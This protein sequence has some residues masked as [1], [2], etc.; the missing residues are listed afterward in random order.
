MGH[1]GVVRWTAVDWSGRRT[2]EGRHLWVAT[3]DAAGTM[4]LTS[5]RS[6]VQ[7][8]ADLIA[9][10]EHNAELVVGLDLSFGLPSWYLD[11]LGVA[12]APGLWEVAA[13]RGEQWLADCPWPFW[14]RPQRPRP[15][16][17]EQYR[18]TEHRLRRAGLPAKAT[19]QIGGAG[20]VG[21]GSVRGWPTLLALRRAGFA[22]WPFDPPRLP[23]VVEVNP[24]A[25]T[26]AVVKSDWAAR[27]AWLSDRLPG[28][29]TAVREPAVA[30]EDAFDALAT[31]T[32]LAA[33]RLRAPD[34]VPHPAAVREGWV[35]VPPAATP[36]PSSPTAGPFWS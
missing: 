26:G 24:R 10:A 6:R 23:L 27:A 36:A 29:A 8:L 22:V 20:A 5:G 1:H 12:D 14:G 19:F 30:S 28:L 31:A 2:G 7:V 32:S 25:C 13:E 16:D 34:P 3:T 21:T 18:E 11:R 15:P 4:E 17:V 9:G 35:W 33:A